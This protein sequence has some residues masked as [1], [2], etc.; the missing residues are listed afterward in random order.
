MEPKPN[1]PDANQIKETDLQHHWHPF[2]D[3]ATLGKD[4]LRL[5]THAKGSYIWDSEGN[6]VLDGMAGLWCVN[7]G[8]GRDEIVDAVAAQMRDLPYYNT[9]FKSTHA[10]VAALAEKIAS[11]TP[12]DLNRI[13][14]NTSGSD[15]N[16]S[17]LR[18]VRTYWESMGKPEK[19]V[20]IT[21]KNAYHGSTVAGVSLG[22]MAGM[23][24]QGGPMVPDIAHIDQPYWYEEGGDMDPAE[25]G[26]ARAKLLE[27]EIDR[28]GEEKVAAFFAEPIQGAGGVIIPPETY[29]PEIN[30]I[31]KERDILLITDEVICGFGR[32][33]EWFGAIHY[34]LEPD[35][36]TMAKGLS[37]GYLPIGALAVSDKIARQIFENAGE[38][39]HGYTYSGHP[40]CCAAA[41]KN[42]EIIE[43]EGL[44]DRTRTHTGPLF[45]DKL[46]TLADHPMVGEVRSVGLM[47]AIELVA[48]KSS[49]K[50]FDNV[51]EVGTKCRDKCFENGLIMRAVRDTMV[52]SPPLV[53][54]DGEIGEL[55]EKAWK[56][57]DQAWQEI[58]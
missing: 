21:R 37:S 33:G 38:Y 53:I 22:G 23:Q 55:V 19:R 40:A 26:L 36:M 42:I 51:G 2:T 43:R 39:V 56:S 4:E 48:D 3:T 29:W 7:V 32:L 58:G 11:T 52:I 49:R 14:F 54:T 16:D 5:I 35:M 9:F 20:I 18:T 15:S 47:A 1:F 45:H 8:Y 13:F 34:G 44:V 27:E 31:C 41:L 30:R 10:P 12:G 17:M 50:R 57:I 25:F 24:A 28:I 46:Q 6:P